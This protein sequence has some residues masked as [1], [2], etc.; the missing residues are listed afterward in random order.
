MTGP[1]D[2]A[3]AGGDRLRAGRADR[4][5]VIEA[6]KNAFVHGR[7]TKDELDARAGQALAAWTYADLAA[8]TADIPPAPAPAP[9]APGRPAAPARRRPLAR[10]AAGS[11]GC[12]V[13][14][15]AAMQVHRLADPG[16]IPGTLPGSLALPSF[17]VA[18]TAVLAAL[19]IVI[20]GVGT[21][22]EQRHSRRQLPARRRAW[23]DLGQIGTG[24]SATEHTGAGA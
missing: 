19:F 9:A 23:S 6:L 15:F 17:L 22:V 14:A 21:A 7:L 10:A 8:L 24:T 12:L 1:Q 13:I 4:E 18:L 11:G 16:N 20:Y 2:P 5:Q 3:A